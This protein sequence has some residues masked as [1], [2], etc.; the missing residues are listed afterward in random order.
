MISEPLP[1]RVR[2][3]AVEND[4]GL[5]GIGGF[6]YQPNDTIAAFVL[7]RPEAEKYP[8]ALH[9]A[10]LMAMAEAK[11]LGYRRVVALADKANEAAERWLERLGFHQVTVDGEQAWVWEADR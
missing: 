3:W 5:L 8:V 4:E 10:G 11:R 1:W 2:A 9:R 7:K 6:A